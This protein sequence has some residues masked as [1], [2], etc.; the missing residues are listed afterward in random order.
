VWKL[1]EEESPTCLLIG[2]RIYQCT[3]CGAT[4]GDLLDQ[5]HHSYKNNLYVYNRDGTKSFV[6]DYG[7]GTVLQNSDGENL[8]VKVMAQCNVTSLKLKKG[9]STSKVKVTLESGDSVLSWKSSNTAIVKVSGKSNGTCK[10]KAQQK[11]GTATIT[12][13]LYSGLKKTIKVTVQKKAVTTSRI[14]GVPSSLSMS[15]GQKYSLTSSVSP[16]TSTQKL[17]YQS[18]NKKR[19]TVS[20]K[21][22]ITAKKKGTVTITVKS[23]T[24]KVKCKITIK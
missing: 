6:C 23:G 7:C 24:K 11:T 16:I 19:A 15:V 8:T 18:S 2:Y 5:L 17:T 14:T 13:T 3:S 4:S 1:R 12:V 22:V 10:I 21:G 9:Q 20:S